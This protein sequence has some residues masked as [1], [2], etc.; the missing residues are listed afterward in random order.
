MPRRAGPERQHF[1]GDNGLV[2]ET[3]NGTTKHYW[4]YNYC[5][6]KLG[7]KVFANSKARIHLSGDPEL[8]NGIIAKVCKL[9]PPPIKV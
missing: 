3:S 6:F 1:G 5:D 7:G 9:A 2:T 4:K 8:T